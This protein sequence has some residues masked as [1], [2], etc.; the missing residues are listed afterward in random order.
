MVGNPG[1][2]IG[3][4]FPVLRQPITLA[5]FTDLLTDVLDELFTGLRQ[6]PGFGIDVSF[7]TATTTLDNSSN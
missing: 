2:L 5:L 4:R 3:C 1:E 6:G 7:T